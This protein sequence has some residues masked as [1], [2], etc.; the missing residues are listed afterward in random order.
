M[1]CSAQP[2]RATYQPDTANHRPRISPTQPITG[3]VSA[4]HSQSQATY[5]P[6][7]AN[8]G[9]RIQTWGRGATFSLTLSVPNIQNCYTS[10]REGGDLQPD[11]VCTKQTELLHQQGEGDDLETHKHAEAMVAAMEQN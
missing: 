6:D 8:H 9:P 4:R 10:R 11:L 1:A 5:Q 2:I 3:H 7:T